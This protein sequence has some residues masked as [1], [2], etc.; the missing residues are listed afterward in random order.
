MLKTSSIDEWDEFYKG[1]TTASYFQSPGWSQI[2]SRYSG[3]RYRPAPLVAEL[4]SGKK[5]L[6]PITR[7]R[8]RGGLGSLWHAAPAGTYGGWLT[9]PGVV[10]NNAETSLLI[11]SLFRHCGSLMLR[12]FPMTPVADEEGFL[13]DIG[14]RGMF[15]DSGNELSGITILDDHTRLIDCAA[16]YEA[17][18]GKWSAGKGSM[19]A[20]VQKAIRSGIQIRKVAAKKDIARYHQLY[21][22][23]LRRWDPPPSHQYT[24]SFF[25]FILETAGHSISGET[26]KRHNKLA[27]NRISREVWVAEYKD[28]IVAGAVILSGKGHMAYWHGVSDPEYQAYRPV[29]LLLATLIEQCCIRGLRWF[30]FNPS[31]GIAGVD[32]F[33]Q[34]FGAQAVS[35]P[36]LKKTTTA[37]QFIIT[38]GSFMRRLTKG[39]AG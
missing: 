10:L 31:L 13:S 11:Q 21:M 2:W 38:A 3:G 9:E 12:L 37:V 29:N 25:E 20:K 7:Q 16:G 39:D 27:K 6:V 4:P 22:D 19:K 5:V 23:A 18:Q 8:L 1:A 28:E 17:I 14:N 30:D 15:T 35:S 26:D 24:A 33:K 34:S 32:R 36:V